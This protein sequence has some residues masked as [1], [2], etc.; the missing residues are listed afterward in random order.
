MPVP[1]HKQ[2]PPDKGKTKSRSNNR[3]YGSFPVHHIPFWQ[4][5][6]DKQSPENPEYFQAEFSAEQK[7]FS[8]E[9]QRTEKASK[10]VF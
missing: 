6:N 10:Q 8:Y 7:T 9:K 1:G 3:Y 5:G 2:S 4:K